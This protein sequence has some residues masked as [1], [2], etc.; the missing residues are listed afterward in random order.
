MKKIMNNQEKKQLV[1][2]YC[3][4]WHSIDFGEGIISQGHKST[5]VHEREKIKWFPSDFFKDKRVLDVGTLDGYYAFYAEQAGASEVI[6]VDKFVWAETRGK[7]KRGFDIAKQILN[8]KVKEHILY[9]EDMKSEVLGTFDSII[10]AGVFYHLQNPY[11]ALEILD[12]LLNNNGRIIIETTMRNL[13][14]DKPLMEFHPKKTLN[15]DP[16]NF[17]SPNTL[18][19]RLMFEEIG[20]Y[21]VEKIHEGKRGI[22]IVKKVS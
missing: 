4:W 5:I 2:S 19:L 8:S 1:D 13:E 3:H 6:A 21:V 17:W 9:I 22:M 12:K 14:I 7:C 15:N 10:F 18:C 20:N 16:T 11:R